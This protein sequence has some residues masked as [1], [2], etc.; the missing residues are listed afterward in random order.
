MHEDNDGGALRDL[1]GVAFL[2][3]FV[4]GALALGYSKQG[5]ASIPVSA[6]PVQEHAVPALMLFTLGAA[7]AIGGLSFAWFLRRRHNREIAANAL[8]T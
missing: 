3:F 5:Y 1:F 2:A 8:T 7:I 6:V 4:M